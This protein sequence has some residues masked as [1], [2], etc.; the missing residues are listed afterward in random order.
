MND[1]SVKQRKARP[2]AAT[3]IYMPISEIKESTVVLKNGGIRAILQTSSVNFNLKSEQE[4]NSIIYGF[5]NF[6]NSIDFPVQIVIRS[7]KLDID[8]Y[9]D[10]LNEITQKQ[11]N[12]LLKKQSLEYIEYIK[13]LVEYADIMEKN[14]F[15]IVPY[16]PLR[17]KDP[18]MWKIFW[19]GIHPGDTLESIRQRHKEFD[20][21]K[22]GLENRV[23]LVKAGL[24]NC[25]LRVE[26]LDTKALVELFFQIYNPDT[27]RNQKLNTKE[28]FEGL[29][30][31]PV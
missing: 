3:Q 24:E 10:N 26:R 25:N 4:Q 20:N 7:K 16:D 29:D 8:N 18:S 2:Q 21:L 30:I 11:E 6:L 1:E 27:A 19:Q 12:P 5:Q 28:G 15:V 22:K 23:N 9:L 31:L 14:F 13:K 17:A